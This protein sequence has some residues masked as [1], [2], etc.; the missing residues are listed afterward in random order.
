MATNDERKKATSLQQAMETLLALE[1]LGTLTSTAAD[2]VRNI[3]AE[4][5]ANKFGELYRSFPCTREGVQIRRDAVPKTCSLRESV[6]GFVAN[7]NTLE[8]PKNRSREVQRKA[9]VQ[10]TTEKDRLAFQALAQ[11][12][13]PQHKSNLTVGQPAR[14]ERVETLETPSPNKQQ[15]EATKGGVG[16]SQ[17]LHQDILESGQKAWDALLAKKAAENTALSRNYDQRK[18]SAQI[19]GKP[20]APVGAGVYN[21]GRTVAAATLA[22]PNNGAITRQGGMHPRS[23]GDTAKVSGGGNDRHTTPKELVKPPS[24][25]IPES[26]EDLIDFGV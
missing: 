14:Y 3:V 13:Q 9:A 26:S 22:A 4:G 17:S 8:K 10:T 21:G 12:N 16:A 19:A 15:P 20:S 7:A 11:V 1:N 23:L 18:Q 6:E 25:P 24:K 2:E 5:I